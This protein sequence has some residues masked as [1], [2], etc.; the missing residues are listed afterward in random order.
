VK[1]EAA[2]RAKVRVEARSKMRVKVEKMVVPEAP[3]LSILAKILQIRTYPVP[4]PKKM[5]RNNKVIQ[6]SEVPMRPHDQIK[7]VPEF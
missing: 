2:M 4:T 5:T 7:I 6:T 1:V 3:S